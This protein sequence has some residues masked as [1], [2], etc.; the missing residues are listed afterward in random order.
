MT[1]K[2]IEDYGV[3]GDTQTVALVAR[4]AAIEW[5]CLP[6][7][8]SDACFAA[9]LGDERHGHWSFTVGADARPT[10]RRYREQT[11]I[12]ETDLESAE[13]AVRVVDFMPPRER[14]PDLV[15]IVEGLRGRVTVRS[16]LRPRFDYGS[17]T[18]WTRMEGNRAVALAGPDALV[19]TAPAPVTCG[20]DAIRSDVTV[21]RGERRALVL[22]W[23]PSNRPMPE[24]I[25]AQHA[26]AATEAWWREWC[27]RCTYEGR[28][29]DPV[30]RSLITLKALTY[31]PTGGIVA[32]A[33][34]S[35]PERLGGVR[36]WDY[37][38]CWLRDA[39]FTLYALVNA[40]F[41]GEAAAW[42]EWL[43]RAVAG[44]PR[45]LQIMYGPAGERRLTEVELG[46][47]PGYEGSRP[48]RIGN[49]AHRQRQLDV[50]G[51]LMDAMHQ[52]R[53][54][55]L[56]PDAAAWDLQ[57][58]LLDHLESAW[59][60]PD[61]GIWEVR[62]PQRHFTHSKV[63]AW[64]AFDRAVKTVERSGLEGPAD[65]WRRLAAK[66]HREVCRE[67]Y[68]ADLGSF[69]QYYGSDRLD[70]SLLMIPLVG[71]LPV[72]DERVVGTINA[73]QA[74][75]CRDGFL[76]RYAS[77]KQVTS[78][79]GLP[80]GEGA[81]LPCT[82]WLA[83]TL[84]LLGRTGEATRIF[85]RLLALRNDLGLLSEEYDTEGRR[86]LGNFPQAFTHV[87]LVNTAL[88][89]E[90]VGGPAERRGREEERESRARGS[91]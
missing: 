65:R 50:Y 16:E 4:D 57:C 77:D 42:R 91:A 64:L 39:T 1:S 59:R 71:F 8:D 51:E 47:L 41:T 79:D 53:R 56:A 89:L 28:W 40:G 80:P 31:A 45:D 9:L 74:R 63:M 76:H 30:E 73:I 68:D 27:A 82:F 37:R 35:L 60:E 72:D 85:E 29:R 19:L 2:P 66:I 5:L 12:L 33:T 81:F 58:R 83:D 10:G 46:W 21:A 36:N 55:G 3:V 75:L 54:G 6:R 49:A 61:E 87:G 26:L 25:D 48:I 62:G 7:F 14:R 78:M 34:T 13:G 38:F 22:T 52:A 70:A 69:V 32:A 67:G 15:R 17:V 86:L 44:D 90:P 43:L 20:G 18:P 84:A 24:P 11:L 23:F 88:N